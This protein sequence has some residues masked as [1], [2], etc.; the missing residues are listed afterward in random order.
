M[1]TDDK[2]TASFQCE[3]ELKAKAEAFAES[4]DRS[5]SSLCRIALWSLLGDPERVFKELKKHDR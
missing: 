1:G 2:V 3:P 5:F 4:Q